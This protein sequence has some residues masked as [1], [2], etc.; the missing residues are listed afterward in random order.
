ML[1]TALP[2]APPT[3]NTMMRAFI[4]RISV[5]AGHLCPTIAPAKRCPASRRQT[6]VTHAQPCG[7][8]PP[9]SRPELPQPRVPSVD[10]AIG[11]GTGPQDGHL[12]L[13]PRR[14]LPGGRGLGGRMQQISHQAI[15]ALAFALEIGAVTAGHGFEPADLRL[16]CRNLGRPLGDVAC[17]ATTRAAVAYG[18]FRRDRR[19][20]G[21]SRHPK[22]SAASE[23]AW[24]ANGRPPT[25]CS[26]GRR[27]RHRSETST[28]IGCSP[29]R[30]GR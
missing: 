15:G 25:R 21:L 29:E 28:D 4:S 10:R 30:T 23:A 11:A 12:P 8:T 16:Q 19:S 26:G 22:A 2:P 6:I 17:L 20:P 7:P 18:V 9:E 13:K 5:H 27:A 1:L 24:Q 14:R 3:P